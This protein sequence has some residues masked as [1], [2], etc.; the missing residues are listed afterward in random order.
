MNQIHPIT[1]ESL[2]ED[3]TE[4]EFYADFYDTFCFQ[5]DMLLNITDFVDDVIA[6]IYYYT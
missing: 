5:Y 4:E 3:G 6:D 1:I 2:M